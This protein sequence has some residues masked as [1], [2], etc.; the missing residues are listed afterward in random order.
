MQLAIEKARLKLDSIHKV[1]ID[2]IDQHE[3]ECQKRF[4][5]IQQNKSDIDKVLHE[6]NQ[7][8]KMSSQLLKEFQIEE[9]SWKISLDFAHHLLTKLEATKKDKIENEMLNEC[10]LK[11]KKKA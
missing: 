2:K 8:M 6:S 3:R 11:F 5:L 10:V 7:F 9:N 1:F 4:K